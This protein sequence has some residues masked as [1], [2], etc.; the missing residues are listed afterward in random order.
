[1]NELQVKLNDLHIGTI[2]IKGKDEVYKFEYTNEWKESGYEIS[3]YFIRL[4]TRIH[5]IAFLPFL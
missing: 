3:P 2:G 4:G 1:M 5:L